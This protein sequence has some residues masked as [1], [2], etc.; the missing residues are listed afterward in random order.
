MA[1]L[2]YPTNAS[3]YFHNELASVLEHADGYARI[4][5][6]PV[7][8][9]SGALRAVYEQVLRLLSSSGFTKILSDHQLRTPLLPA[10]QLWLS[11]E[12]VPRAIAEAGYR[13]GAVVEAHD[14]LSR[15]SVVR[16][17]Q[18]LDRLPLTI[19]Y[20]EDAQLAAAWLRCS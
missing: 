18:Q 10:D 2:L 11:Q 1:Y 17:V 9:Q 20:F 14:L 6:S 4:D 12:W 16:V 3:L 19:R 8:L 15:S 5:W 13:H 7:P